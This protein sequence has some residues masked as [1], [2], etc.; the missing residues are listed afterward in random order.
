MSYMK[1]KLA[2]YT[3]KSSPTLPPAPPSLVAR[4]C[5]AVLCRWKH[6]ILPL[7]ALYLSLSLSLSLS[8][9]LNYVNPSVHN[10]GETNGL[11]E[12][13]YIDKHRN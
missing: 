5:C 9:V 8:L 1:G 6:D 3:L 2:Q 4:D 11:D 10:S 7:I 12:V 13:N